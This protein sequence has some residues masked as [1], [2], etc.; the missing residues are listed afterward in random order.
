MEKAKE[1]YIKER[2]KEKY[3]Y[4]LQQRDDL[5]ETE[6]RLL[7]TFKRNRNHSLKTLMG[8]YKGHYL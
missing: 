5:D 4:R 3:N 8:L 7:E 1:S 6:W 2:D